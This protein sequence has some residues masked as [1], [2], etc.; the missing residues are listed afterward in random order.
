[1]DRAVRTEQVTWPLNRPTPSAL[2]ARWEVQR[3][4]MISSGDPSLRTARIDSRVEDYLK[5]S[6]LRADKDQANEASR[7]AT[8]AHLVSRA[9]MIGAEG[10]EAS[11]AGVDGGVIR[12]GGIDVTAGARIGIVPADVWN[13]S[14]SKPAQSAEPAQ[15]KRQAHPLE[16]LGGVE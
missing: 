5:A 15:P 16:S 3:I 11:A 8:V 9:A 1:V 10:V 13:E 2:V 6:Q 14:R 4:D 12:T 7:L